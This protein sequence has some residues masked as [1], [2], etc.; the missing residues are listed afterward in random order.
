VSDGPIEPHGRKVIAV[1][2]INDYAAWPTLRNAVSDARGALELFTRL[3]FELAAAPLFDRAATGDALRR[4]VAD[5]LARLGPEDSLVVFFAGHG[6][7]RTHSL[8][9]AVIKTGYIIP[10][11]GGAPPGSASTWVRLDSW[12]S[13]IARLPVKHVLVILDACY[14][15]VALDAVVTWRGIADDGP[16]AEPLAQLRARQSRRVITS[17]LENQ[18]ALDSG[19]VPGHSLFTGCLIE[20]L[21]GGLAR[22]GKRAVTGSELGQ[23]VQRRVTTFPGSRQTPDFGAL[24]LDDRGEMVLPIVADPARAVSASPGKRWGRHGR[25]ILAANVAGLALLAALVWSAVM[26]R[27]VDPT[28]GSR[29]T[30]DAAVASVDAAPALDAAPADAANG[31]ADAAIPVFL[32]DGPAGPADAAIVSVDAPPPWRPPRRCWVMRDDVHAKP[33][34]CTQRGCPAGCINAASEDAP[35]R[36]PPSAFE[37]CAEVWICEQAPVSR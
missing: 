36:V 12:L 13:D 32:T 9:N 30:P 20:A 2:G 33:Q 27:G 17:A 37:T 35:V 10:A 26:G 8:A 23:Y 22:D 18:R 28:G 3:G 1:A 24:E 6:F 16:T 29:R 7:T 15:G 14:S 4:L 19:P 34:H 25:T 11:N 31:P 5:D 21:T